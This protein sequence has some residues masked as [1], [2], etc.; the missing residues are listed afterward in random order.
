MKCPKCGH[1]QSEQDECRSC[2]I[3]FEKYYELERRRREAR[4]A[5]DMGVDDSPGDR[6]RNKSGLLRTLIVAGACVLAGILFVMFKP[7]KNSEQNAA[8][9]H[10]TDVPSAH[11][12]TSDNVNT[13]T[14]SGGIAQQIESSNHARTPIEKAR[15]AAVF[16]TSKI[17]SGSGFFIDGNCYILT[18]RHVIHVEEWK[19]EQLQREFEQVKE[20]VSWMEK[21]LNDLLVSFKNEGIDIDLENPPLEI[22]DQLRAYVIV[23]SRYN[24]LEQYLE[25]AMSISPDIDVTL[26]D[27]SKHDAVVIE[28]SDDHDLALLRIYGENC[29]C[30][31]PESAKGL[32]FGQ[33]VHTVGNPKGYQHIVTSGVISSYSLDGDDKVIQTDAPINPGNSGGPLITEQGNVI[34]INTAKRLDAEGIGFAIPIEVALEEFSHH[35]DV[36]M[37]N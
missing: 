37:T 9:K 12:A 31:K 10:K 27:G 28:I 24:F 19:K 26:V 23:K 2:G 13:T 30:I 15:N 35:V 16:I 29:P 32:P 14:P 1:L 11:L 36:R 17:G 6:S 8:M 22:A 5:E 3:V 33:R 25:G 34:G 18:N 7:V 4:D 20:Q 21:G